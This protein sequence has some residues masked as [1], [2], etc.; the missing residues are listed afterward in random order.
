M[1]RLESRRMWT[2]GILPLAIPA[3]YI[4]Q[5]LLRQKD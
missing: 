2:D 5:P 1:V 3:P 4:F